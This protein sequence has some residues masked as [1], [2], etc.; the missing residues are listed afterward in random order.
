MNKLF[1]LIFPVLLFSCGD[2]TNEEVEGRYN[3]FVDDLEKV[4]NEVFS[5]Q[6]KVDDADKSIREEAS[7]LNKIVADLEAHIN[8]S[9]I[10]EKS[11]RKAQDQQLAEEV[12]NLSKKIGIM[13]SNLDFQISKGGQT[14]QTNQQA[15]LQDV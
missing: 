10:T 12:D 2:K 5:M 14:S 13:S 4:V 7:K 8:T 1:F 6:N 11:V 3:A 9:I 15:L